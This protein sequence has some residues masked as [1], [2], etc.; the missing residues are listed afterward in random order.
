MT[1]DHLPHQAAG[2]D[3]QPI[4]FAEAGVVFIV[5]IGFVLMITG[6]GYLASLF[7]A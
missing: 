6:V 1:T 4:T 7:T 5:A 3:K 2:H